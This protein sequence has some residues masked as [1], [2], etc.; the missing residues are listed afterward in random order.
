MGLSDFERREVAAVP[1][2]W[3]EALRGV[4]LR[5][6]RHL[7]EL[8]RGRPS[9]EMLRKH[10]DALRPLPD[11]AARIAWLECAM[12]RGLRAPAAPL[13]GAKKT[14]VNATKPKDDHDFRNM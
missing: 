10:W 3:G 8:L 13:N 6:L 14:E 1:A 5:W 9:T 12:E 11:D 2:P 4:W 7:T